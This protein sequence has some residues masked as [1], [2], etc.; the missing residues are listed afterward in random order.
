MLKLKYIIVDKIPP[1]ELRYL[2]QNLEENRE[3]ELVELDKEK[4]ECREKSSRPF[5]RK[6]VFSSL[7][8]GRNFCA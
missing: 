8:R 2:R 7:R 3:L 5:R 4:E 6:T 1:A